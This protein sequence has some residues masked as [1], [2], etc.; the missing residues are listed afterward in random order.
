M[1]IVYGI[2]K[3]NLKFMNYIYLVLIDYI[4]FVVRCFK[5]G[6]MIENYYLFEIKEFNLKEYDIGKYVIIVFKEVFGL[7]L[8]EEEIG[9]IVGYFIN[10]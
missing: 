6:I 9:N 4:V 10:V 3:Y 8:L 5:E 7:D 2:E 1:I